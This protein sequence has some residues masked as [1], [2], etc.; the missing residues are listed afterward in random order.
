MFNWRETTYTSHFSSGSSK[1]LCRLP[2]VKLTHKNSTFIALKTFFL[3]AP[4]Q[5][6]EQQPHNQFNVKRKSNI[7]TGPCR[8]LG[9]WLTSL[10]PYW[11]LLGWVAATLRDGLDVMAIQTCTI[12]KGN[13]H[14]SYLCF[15]TPQTKKTH[16]KTILPVTIHSFLNNKYIVCT[17]CTRRT[18]L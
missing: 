18:G 11:S 16:I 9:K 6:Y 5:F 3:T 10:V 1:I 14:P 15:I 7:L 12:H 4:K 2:K 8:P 17:H 13:S